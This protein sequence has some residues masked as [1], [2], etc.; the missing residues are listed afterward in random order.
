MDHGDLKYFVALAETRHFARAARKAHI[1]PSALT[2]AIQRLEA[3]VDR[4][5]FIRDR[6]N[7]KLTSAG[8]IFQ[9]YAE[10]ALADWETCRTAL[11]TQGG[12]VRGSIS[13]Y[14]SVTGV[15]T[16]LSEVL[17]PFRNRYPEVHVNLATGT[18]A[19]A[20]GNV[21]DGTVDCAVAA[22]PDKLPPKVS[23]LSL[24]ATSLVFIAPVGFRQVPGLDPKGRVDWEKT[25]IIMPDRDVARE[26]QIRW[27]TA[28]HIEP[29]VFAEVAGNEA[30]IAMVSL[31]FGVGIVPE[32]VLNQSP[33]NEKVQ[34]LKV[35][36]PLP[37]YAIGVVYL[38]RR[39]KDPT[40]AAFCRV[41]EETIGHTER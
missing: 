18:V 37:P 21:L 15:Y 31:G 11:K 16:I 39:L 22:M 14:S 25:P 20:I 9:S 26:R 41:A 32:I 12:T 28:Q 2:R 8:R 4:P 40:I 29:T 24:T 13:L 19:D 35:S 33:L 1:S 38:T 27:F 36:P 30:I 23:F 10:G 34:K 5:L 17:R 3:E 7:V 6:R